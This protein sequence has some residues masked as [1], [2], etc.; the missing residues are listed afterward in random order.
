MA[1]SQGQGVILKC[2]K[3]PDVVAHA[4]NSSPQEAE[5]TGGGEAG[6]RY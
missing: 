1:Q 2:L 6:G 4:C 3:Q 5:V